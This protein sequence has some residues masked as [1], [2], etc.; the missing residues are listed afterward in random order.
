MTQNADQ[1]TTTSVKPWYRQFWPWFLIA[2]PATSV[3]AGLSTLAI[4][5]LNQDSLVRDDWYKDG[6]AINQSLA[7][8]DAAAALGLSAELQMDHVTGEISA[9][10]VSAKSIPAPE[11]LTLT[12]SHPTLATQDQSVVLTRRPDGHYQGMLTHDLQGRHYIE[13]GNAEWRLRSTRDFPLDKLTL[14]HEQH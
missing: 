9:I 2:L 6:K 1:A 8:D 10:L 13:L 3:V 4:A 5:I 12:L 14:V 11:I 7:R